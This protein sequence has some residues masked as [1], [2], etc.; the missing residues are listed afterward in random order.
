MDKA[1]AVTISD[2]RKRLQRR[3]LSGVFLVLAIIVLFLFSLKIGTYQFSWSTLMEILGGSDREPLLTHV[4]NRIRLPRAL[5][6]LLAGAALGCSGAAMQNVLRNPLASPFTLGV[7]QG[8]ACG[9]AFAIIVLGAGLP[10]AEGLLSPRLA[11]Y[12]V[13]LA[14]FIGA[15]LTVAVLTLLAY[16]REITPESLILS[17]VALSAFFGALT[18][19]LQYFASDVEVAGTVFWTFGDLGKARPRDLYLIAL[20][21][22][23]VLLYLWRQGWSFN[24]LLWGDDTALSLGIEVGRLRLFTLL[25]TSLLAAVTIAFLG[26]I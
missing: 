9:A 1:S 23:P 22:F 26:I 18:M 24:A 16:F 6:A 15:L 4:I 13:V 21:L 25:L 10:Q 19:L 12:V 7:S 17:G 8:A 14:A 2:Y 3:N 11:P 20:L 5:A